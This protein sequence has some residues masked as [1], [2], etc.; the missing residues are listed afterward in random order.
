MPTASTYRYENEADARSVAETRRASW[1]G[2]S[3]VGQRS[4]EHD[5]RGFADARAPFDRDFASSRHRNRYLRGIHQDTLVTGLQDQ[6]VR[7]GVVVRRDAAQPDRVSA[8]RVGR[9]QAPNLSDRRQ[10]TGA[11]L[12][13]AAAGHTRRN[14]Q[15]ER[16]PAGGLHRRPT[17]GGGIVRRQFAPF[18]TH[19]AFRE[20]GAALM[21]GRPSAPLLRQAS[22]AGADRWA[23]SYS[24]PSRPAGS[25]RESPLIA[26]AVMARIRR[27]PPVPRSRR[28]I[29]A[30]ASNPSISGICTSISTRSKVSRASA[31]IASRPLATAVTSWPR[32]TSRPTATRWLT[33][34]SSATSTLRRRT[35]GL[36]TAIRSPATAV[37]SA[38]SSASGEM[39]CAAD[40][41]LA[42]EP[43]ASTHQRD[44]R[45]GNREAQAR[46]PE[47]AR[48]RSVCLA[49]GF[50]DAGLL[51]DRYADARVGH[52]EVQRRAVAGD[53]LANRHHDVTAFG[54]LE[55]IPDEIRDDLLEPDGIA[56]DGLG[57]VRGD[58][59]DELEALAIALGPPAAS[60]R[61]RSRRPAQTGSTRAPAS[62]TRSSRSRECR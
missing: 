37:S 22:E 58:V 12:R 6:G 42:L 24:R 44:E 35:G 48:G 16:P 30:V 36:A 18:T 14:C 50:E 57:N 52:R 40:V 51:L 21:R 56:G 5:G 23:C 59:R 31:S 38:A 34:L 49:E 46:P 1:S 17:A 60:R 25:A 19:L 55:R 3:E 45:R 2:G 33:T 11:R 28:R 62:A 53:I 54:E 9:P 7:R 47:S 32:L 13:S 15:H 43:D 20:P 41:G 8:L 61:C 26:C 4:A 10:N 39:K 29:S 27:C